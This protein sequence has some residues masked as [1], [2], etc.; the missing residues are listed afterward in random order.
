MS[1]IIERRIVKAFDY[2]KGGG[3]FVATF[4]LFCATLET[5]M[6]GEKK[7]SAPRPMVPLFFRKSR[8]K[9]RL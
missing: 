6:P 7:F 8:F 2:D 9:V 1:R 5:A 3:R 4:G